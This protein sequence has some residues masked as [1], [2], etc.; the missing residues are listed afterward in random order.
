[1]LWT[2]L[3]AESLN[4]QMLDAL[5]A[6][7]HPE[8]RYSHGF[9]FQQLI[10]GSR[11]VGEIA[12]N[13]GVTSQ[14][15][16][17]AVRELERLGYVRRQADPDDARVRRVGLTERGRDAVGA[18]RSVREEL[19]GRLAGALGAERVAAAASTLAAAMRQSG[20]LDAVRTRRVRPAQGLGGEGR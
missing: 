14:A 8:L 4:E 12:A 3:L 5:R 11:P 16:S 19:N 20:A 7:G 2:Q 17:K 18:A 15:V 9:L 13:L 1:M 10:E 6:R